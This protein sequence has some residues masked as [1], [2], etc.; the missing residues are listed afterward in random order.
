MLP[1]NLKEWTHEH[2]VE[3]VQDR[4]RKY[5]YDA[6]VASL[7]DFVDGEELYL[8]GS[9]PDA[10]VRCFSEAPQ[11]IR[12]DE[13]R[14]RD[15]EIVLGVLFKDL[16]TRT[17][18][19]PAPGA[20]GGA[21]GQ[22][23]TLQQVLINGI[24]EIKRL[25]KQKKKVSVS[26]ISQT[27]FNLL[28]LGE[29]RYLPYHQETIPTY[30]ALGWEKGKEDSKENMRNVLARFKELTTLQG[31][32]FVSVASKT[33]FN[34]DMEDLEITG[35]TDI[36]V[37]RSPIRSRDIALTLMTE[38]QV[39]IELKKPTK[40]RKT[41]SLQ[42]FLTQHLIIQLHSK[43]SILSL[44]TDMGSNW[45]IAWTITLGDKSMIAT[46]NL[47]W[48]HA[49]RSIQLV[50]HR[51]MS[52]NVVNP[53]KWNIT[54][55]LIESNLI[56][57]QP[58]AQIDDSSD[59]DG[60]DN[61]GGDDGSDDDSEGDDKDPPKDS[62]KRK[63]PTS[64][65]KS[66][67]K[68]PKNQAAKKPA[69]KKPAA[70]KPAAKKPAGKKRSK[71]LGITSPHNGGSM[72]DVANLQDVDYLLDKDDLASMQR[73]GIYR[74]LRAMVPYLSRAGPNSNKIII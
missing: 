34:E 8:A 64:S 10:F 71:T 2:A 53:D 51:N 55:L 56:T 12:D 43:F 11:H 36:L 58:T 73:A 20:A 17:S 13:T 41:E 50:V 1:A 38:T 68:Q 6:D 30:T 44:L 24:E 26:R 63:G 62:R 21:G 23:Q 16:Q 67:P 74:I 69:A 35:G 33:L 42:Q 54:Q 25:V 60:D 3:W 5:R 4:I 65:N 7:Q 52:L 32:H 22:A 72:S 70:K 40:V 45:F 31:A 18:A 61:D 27:D 15:R 59:E 19:I 49:I 39:H 9:S 46:C 37:C 28:N 57:P 47:P 66:Q 14:T 48:N 29:V